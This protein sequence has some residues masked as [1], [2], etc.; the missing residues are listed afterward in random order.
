MPSPG[1]K[2]GPSSRSSAVSTSETRNSLVSA[3]ATLNDSQYRAECDKQN[4]ECN[5][6][7]SG[8]QLAKIVADTYGAPKSIVDKLKDLN[9]AR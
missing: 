9:N 6:P 4:L 8:A 7:T 3:T 5:D 1:K 2:C